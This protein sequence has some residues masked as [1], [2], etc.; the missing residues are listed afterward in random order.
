M[1]NVRI[2]MRSLRATPIVTV[3]SLVTLALGIGANTA[4]FS[5][6]YALLLA[7]LGY[8][9]ADRLVSIW[10]RNASGQRNPMTTLNYLD[11]AQTPVFDQVAPT[12]VC[13]GGVILGTG[14]QPLTAGAFHVGATYFDILG[15]RAALGRTFIAGDDRPGRDHVVVI[16]DALWVSQFG[17][18][19]S[20]VGRAI[21]LNGE[22][23]T[24]VGVMPSR[25]PS[26]RGEMVWLPLSFPPEQMIRANHWLTSPYGAAVGLLKPGVTVDRA[27]VELETVAARLAA[28]FPETNSGWGVVVEPYGATLVGAD[29]KRFLLLLLAA[30]GSVLLIGCVNLASLMVARGLARGREVAIRQA[31][32]ARRSQLIRQF[33]TESLILSMAGGILGLA[34]GYTTMTTLEGVLRNQ[35]MNPSFVPYI[36]HCHQRDDGT[37]VLSGRGSGRPASADAGHAAGY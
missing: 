5:F 22:P 32:G 17:A 3:V 10:E 7:P 15:V 33:M 28:D 25:G 8:P 31:L 6:I 26:D 23:Y 13:C 30:V 36:C 29:L 9:H 19:P 4:I 21:R 24:V 35:P 37:P 1:H 11:Y 14:E 12:T 34:L 27:R 2:A 16:N 18:D 20:T